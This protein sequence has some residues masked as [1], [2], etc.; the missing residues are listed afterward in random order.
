MSAEARLKELGLVLPSVPT[1]LANYVPFRLAGN[2]LFLSGQGPRDDKGNAV[3]YRYRAEDGLGVDLT[4]VH[5]SSR[6]PRNDARR[7]ANR[8]LKRILYGNR[9]S[10]LD[11]DTGQRPRFLTQSQANSGDWM[12]E[13]VLDYGDHDLAAP[14]TA[15]AIR[16]L[17]RTISMRRPS[18][19]RW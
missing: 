12:F 8:Y 9:T 4:S 15:A 16:Y 18:R 7:R 11:Q 5:E 13:V 17:T 2:L 6:G 10:L 1:P 3:L 14:S 19:A